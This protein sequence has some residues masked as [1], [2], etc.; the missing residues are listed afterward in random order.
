MAL[1]KE[2]IFMYRFVDKG[3]IGKEETITTIRRLLR[4]SQT[5][6]GDS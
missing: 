3:D 1:S 4:H 2:S 5:V 6:L